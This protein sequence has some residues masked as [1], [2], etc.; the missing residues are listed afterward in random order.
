M[1]LTFGN[2]MQIGLD[3]TGYLFHGQIPSTAVCLTRLTLQNKTDKT[4]PPRMRAPPV[5]PLAHDKPGIRALSERHGL[6]LRAASYVNPRDEHNMGMDMINVR[7]PLSPNA[8]TGG[9]TAP[10]RQPQWTLTRAS[11]YLFTP[12]G[13]SHTKTLVAAQQERRRVSTKERCQACKPLV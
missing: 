5:S 3:P 1:I 13:L 12:F 2:N 10:P 11:P 8:T 7:D 4:A 9:L 6:S